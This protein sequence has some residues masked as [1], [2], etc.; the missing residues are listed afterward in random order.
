LLYRQT[1]PFYKPAAEWALAFGSDTEDNYSALNTLESFR[2]K[3]GKFHLKIKWP[4]DTGTGGEGRSEYNAGN[5]NEWQ[6]VTNFV[7]GAEETAA[8]GVKGYEAVEINYS[9]FANMAA[10]GSNDDQFYGL[11]HGTPNGDDET[12]YSLAD[13]SVDHGYWFYAIGSRGGWGN[14]PGI[15]GGHDDFAEQQVRGSVGIM[16]CLCN[17]LEIAISGAPAST[18][19]GHRRISWSTSSCCSLQQVP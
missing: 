2:G 16:S 6:Q 11:E 8:G 12:P 15:P 4:Q 9:A 3:N 7:T 5:S 17:H 13:G 14:P 1:V 19:S 10:D 18:K